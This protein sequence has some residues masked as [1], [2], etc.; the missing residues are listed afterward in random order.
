MRHFQLK[1][2]LTSLLLLHTKSWND[3]YT[4]A[5]TAWANSGSFDSGQRA[6]QLLER[7]E[8]MYKRGYRNAKPNVRTY[9]AVIDTICR[10]RQG[11]PENAEALLLKMLHRYE[12]GDSDLQPDTF[13]FNAVIQCYTKSKRYDA[14]DKAISLLE[15]MLSL[16][17]EGVVEP[18]ARSFSHIIEYYSRSS[19]KEAPMKAE[20][21]LKTMVNLYLQ[22]VEH[23]KHKS[24]LMPN[25]FSFTAVMTAYTRTDPNPGL[26]CEQILELLNYL[27]ASSK[28]NPRLQPN[29][30]VCNCVLDA[31]SKSGK[32]QARAQKAEEILSYLEQEY[33][34]GQ[35][36]MRP[37]AKTYILTMMCFAKSKEK[38]KAQKTLNILRR[39]QEQ[40]RSGKVS[41][42]PNVQAYSILINAAAF[43][44]HEDIE[45]ENESLY[46]AKLALKELQECGYDKPNSITYGSFLKA[47]GHLN[48]PKGKLENEA[49]RAFMDCCEDGHV[50]E[51]VVTQLKNAVSH[52]SFEELVPNLNAV[53]GKKGWS[54]KN[55]PSEWSR[56]VPN[57]NGKWCNSNI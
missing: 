47:C 6:E 25:L 23:G 11:N 24:K 55:L 2:D 52:V 38:S 43:T 28:Y 13:S 14:G 54:N 39:M 9:N 27:F 44:S 8:E 22:D 46:I 36:Q 40:Y 37:T 32:L 18:D 31:Y 51:Y 45:E 5:I 15:R 19:D 12:D 7:M 56:N 42:Q 20:R 29:A 30:F 33:G 1:S 3:S 34:N 21:L 4:I 49:K 48:L 10:S 50:N 16:H 57:N 35:D 53:E 26:H 17:E 41:T